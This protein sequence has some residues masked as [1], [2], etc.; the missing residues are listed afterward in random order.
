MNPI[1]TASGLPPTVALTDE[2]I[3]IAPLGRI[4]LP[5]GR[6]LFGIPMAIFGIQHFMYAT[7]VHTLMPVW[8]PVRLCG[9]ALVVAGRAAKRGR[10]VT[11]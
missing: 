11:G 1:P 9:G 3:G 2:R 10:F 8:I 4:L 5:L 6:I 7:F